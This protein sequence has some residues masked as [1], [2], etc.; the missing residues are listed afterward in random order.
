MEDLL[1]STNGG[2]SSQN[3]RHLD[4]GS[5]T[6]EIVRPTGQ[7]ETNLEDIRLHLKDIPALCDHYGLLPK[8]VP[9]HP[10]WRY[11]PEVSG[12]EVIISPGELSR[13]FQG[14]ATTVYER[15]VSHFKLPHPNFFIAMDAD[16]R[17]PIP[18]EIS[19]D[20]PFVLRH[21]FVP[22]ENDGDPRRAQVVWAFNATAVTHI[23]SDLRLILRNS[24]IDLTLEDDLAVAVAL[25]RE[26]PSALY[27]YVRLTRPDWTEDELLSFSTKTIEGLGSTKNREF[28]SWKELPSKLWAVET[29]YSVPEDPRDPSFKPLPFSRNG[30]ISKVT[31]D[32]S[33]I[34][35]EGTVADGCTHVRIESGTYTVD[36]PV[37]KF[38][39]FA[40][41]APV[42]TAG[43]TSD[44]SVQGFNPIERTVSPQQIVR[45]RQTSTSIR[46]RFVRLLI[47]THIMAYRPIL[48][49]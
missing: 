27:D 31:T 41:N 37:D 33:A 47:G 4:L 8:A 40:T 35:I 34:R 2:Q 9:D 21:I 3:V 30:A 39:F 18:L 13:Y 24:P 6:I 16:D 10:L 44:I 46:H 26:D 12:S 22:P 23:A 29:V 17:F 48:V 25:L 42:F 36:S 38:G 5:G 49:T 1:L 45:V 19:R 7:A 20:T 43:K 32:S 11:V 15:V 14:D 28:D